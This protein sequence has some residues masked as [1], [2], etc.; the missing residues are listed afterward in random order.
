MTELM[1]GGPPPMIP[2]MI[3]IDDGRSH[4]ETGQLRSV[5]LATVHAPQV[6]PSSAPL[7]S[8]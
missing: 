4:R 5:G 8:C 2:P 1:V 3:S 6:A 7:G